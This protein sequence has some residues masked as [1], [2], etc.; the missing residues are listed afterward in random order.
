MN[1]VHVRHLFVAARSRA[2]SRSGLRSHRPRLARLD[3]TNV[4]RDSRG[5]PASRCGLRRGG[6]GAPGVA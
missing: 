3:L 5:G 4:L 6:A 2:R 1:R